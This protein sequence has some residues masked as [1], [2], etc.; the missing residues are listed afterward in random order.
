MPT[1]VATGPLMATLFLSLIHIFSPVVA[2]TMTTRR[3]VVPPNRPM[4]RDCTG[5]I[6]HGWPSSSIS[7]DFWSN[8]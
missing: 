4:V 6:H 2:S 1:G 5:Q 7:N 3:M 8:M